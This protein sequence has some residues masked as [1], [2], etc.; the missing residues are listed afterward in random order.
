MGCWH[1]VDEVVG[2]KGEER[3]D[4]KTIDLRFSHQGNGWEVFVRV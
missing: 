3:G 2:V 4:F 1:I